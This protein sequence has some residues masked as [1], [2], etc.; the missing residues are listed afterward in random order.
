[1]K[2]NNKAGTKAKIWGKEEDSTLRKL[3]ELPK[4]KSGIDPE[5]TTKAN[6]EKILRYG[7]GRKK[8]WE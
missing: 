1:M 3:L 5:D 8:D 6:L 4:S 7:I 2:N